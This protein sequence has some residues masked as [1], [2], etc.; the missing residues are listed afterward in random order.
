LGTRGGGEGVRLVDV[1]GDNIP[2]IGFPFRQRSA[3]RP[4]PR[5]RRIPGDPRY[6]IGLYKIERNGFKPLLPEGTS[7]SP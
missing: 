5:A 4:D 1:D 3:G 2:E 7:D 6:W